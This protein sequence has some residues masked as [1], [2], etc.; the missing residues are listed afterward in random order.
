MKEW[1]KAIAILLF[2][3]FVVW[4]VSAF[5]SQLAVLKQF[6]SVVREGFTMVSQACIEREEEEKM[7]YYCIGYVVTRVIKE[8]WSE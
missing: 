2:M 4:R 3:L 8:G 6:K 7:Q 5:S 1:L